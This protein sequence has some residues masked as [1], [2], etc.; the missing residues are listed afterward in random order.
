[1]DPTSPEHYPS[2]VW[3]AISS[4]EYR[5]QAVR[6]ILARPK[7]VLETL[8]EAELSIVTPDHTLQ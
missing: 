4:W 5:L 8:D 3:L 6:I 2:D 1:M 7:S